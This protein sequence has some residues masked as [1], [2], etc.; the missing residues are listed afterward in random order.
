MNSTIR[1]GLAA[2]VLA[3]GACVP[4]AK[5]D[6]ALRDAQ[7]ARA[8]AL[9]ARGDDQQQAS[10]VATARAQIAQL[11]ASIA[12]LQARASDRDKMLATAQGSGHELQTKLDGAIAENEQLR[13]ELARLGKN[14][15]AL[16]AEKGTLSS[17]LA[18]AKSRLEDLRKAQAA[19]EA[20]AALFKQLALKFQKMID[21]G[22]LKVALRNGRMVLE[23]PNDVLFDSGQTVI[24]PAGK[25]ALSKIATILRTIS[26][27]HFQVAGDTD[28][29]PIVTAL[30]PSNWELSTRRAV[31][32]VHFLV[33]QGMRPDL[34]SA[35]GFGEF[36]PI[37]P[38]DSAEGRAKNRRIEISLQ[39][40][41]DELVSLP[42]VR[43]EGSG[44]ARKGSP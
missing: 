30:F 43:S 44:E 6:A 22:E 33:A 8:D 39:P 28:N 10:D 26:D 37:A 5:Y 4:Q 7:Q 21:A 42:T 17:A 9:R 1:L 11:N 15:D 31:E 34:L 27:R 24:K 25:Q 13:R 32:V 16:L 3:L 20:R 29:V 40:N 18:D 12:E 23:L 38:N 41:I 2:T 36:D 14:A 35:A 19:A